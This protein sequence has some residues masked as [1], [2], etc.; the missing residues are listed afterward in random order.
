MFHFDEEQ[1]RV[2]EAPARGRMFLYGPAGCGKTTAGVERMSALLN[3]GVPASQILVL[4]PQRTLAQPYQTALAQPGR[5]AGGEVSL[6]TLG[7]IAQRMVSLFWPLAAELA[8]FGHP[9]QPPIFLT[10]ET[11]QYSMARLV[12]PLLAEGF[13]EALTIDRNRLY[14]QL[15]D[16]LN[17]AALAGFPHTEIAARLDAV[18][19][20]DPTQRRIFA[21]V[22]ESVNRFRTVCLQENLLDFSLQFQVFL[23]HLWPLPMVRD[24]LTQTYRHL[25]YD[26]IEEDAPRAH[27]LIREWLPGF[28][29]ALLIYDESAGYRRFLGADVESAWALSDLCDTHIHLP[30][31]FVISNPIAELDHA[32]G[33]AVLRETVPAVGPGVL[34]ADP[35][36]EEAPGP[37]LNWLSSRYYPTLLDAVVSNVETLVNEQAVPPGEIVVLAPY[38]SD[39]LR[40]AIMD[41]LQKRGLPVRSHRPSRSL[42]EEP[43]SHALLTLASLAHPAWEIRP[44]KFDVAYAL[45]Q[46]VAGL[47]LVR[48]QLLAE[49]CYR[50]RDASLH[51]FEDLQAEAQER[52]TFRLGAAYTRLREWILAYRA[53]EPLPLDHFLRKLFGEV[54][55]QPGFGF[56]SNL[57][58]VRVAASLVESVAKFRRAFEPPFDRLKARGGASPDLGQEYL[59]MLED[60]VIAAQYIEAWQIPDEQSILVAPAYTF[61]M[62]NRPADVQIWLDP[63]AG[64]W[65]ERLAQP[66]THPQVLSRS[67]DPGRPWTDAD[68]VQYSQD[69]LARLVS[70]LLRRCR[71]QLYLALPELGESGFEQ[72][73]D[74]LRAFQRVL[75]AS[76]IS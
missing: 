3:T 47:D 33:T 65:Y 27:D 74:L 4:T 40:F 51:P 2:I 9:D 50:A 31:S 6:L 60:G 16:N 5:G 67:W 38:L 58:S 72:R 66:L 8:G 35:N 22:Q 73:G 1:I 64:G 10:L 75:Q 21:D 13:F 76:S 56:H 71:K 39:A 23:E 37:A 42:R 61:L 59:V 24:Y 15:L 18:S 44:P 19:H 30:G 12:R 11:A 25:I 70:G 34:A 28:D 14:A 63:G 48:A 52:I 57:D 46:S 17:K 20:G 55:S 68:E 53:A 62:M 43:A 69:A 26:N 54:L 32:L 49:I 45:M 41:R 7:G 36:L 29:S